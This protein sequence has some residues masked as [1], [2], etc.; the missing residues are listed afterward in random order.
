MDCQYCGSHCSCSSDSI[1]DISGGFESGRFFVGESDTDIEFQ[2][3]GSDSCSEVYEEPDDNE[4][5]DELVLEIVQER[6]IHNLESDD[7]SIVIK[8]K[9]PVA[10][11]V[12]T[13][14]NMKGQ[15]DIKQEQDVANTR[16][17]RWQPTVT[18]K[19][20]KGIS[21]QP[22]LTPLPTAASLASVLTPKTAGTPL[23]PPNTK[24]TPKTLDLNALKAAAAALLANPA[25]MMAITELRKKEFH[26]YIEAQAKT[27][28]K[29]T[30][31][32]SKAIESKLDF[33]RNYRN[34][35][36]RRT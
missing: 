9:A 3:S 12:E 24:A 17:T 13:P 6:L 11:V 30:P 23:K 16:N 32:N 25:A 20:K 1:V 15:L 31:T 22:I 33:T 8:K 14:Q 34:P 19:R 35:K 21:K 10:N 4:K 7:D 28:T 29:T 5:G 27:T 36:S 2:D 26:K 18:P